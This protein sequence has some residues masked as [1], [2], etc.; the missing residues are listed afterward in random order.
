MSPGFFFYSI[1]MVI[2]IGIL[3]FIKSPAGKRWLDEYSE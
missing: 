3:I 1:L 2:A